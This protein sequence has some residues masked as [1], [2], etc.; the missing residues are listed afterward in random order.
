[1]KLDF[2]LKGLLTPLENKTKMAKN[3]TKNHHSF[4]NVI[5]IHFKANTDHNVI[6]KI[7]QQIIINTTKITLISKLSTSS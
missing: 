3:E 5:I 2:K 7:V 4:T 1:M 6:C